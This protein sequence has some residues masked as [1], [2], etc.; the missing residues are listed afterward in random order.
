M[1]MLQLRRFASAVFVYAVLAQLAAAQAQTAAPKAKP[2]LDD[3]IRTL[4]SG[5]TFS[6]VAISPDGK[7]LAWV[8]SAKAGTSAIYVAETGGGPQP[9]RV[10]AGAGA[11]AAAPT[12]DSIAWSPDSKR[13]AFLSDAAK[14]GQA[15][16]YVVGA[17]GGPATK[18]TSVKGFLGSPGW[19]PDGKTIALLFTENAERAAGPLVAEKPQTGEIKEAVTEQRLTVVDVTSSRLRQ[20]SPADM[21]VYEY[22]WSPDGKRFVATA[23]H[24]NGDNNWYLAELYTLHAAGG[25]M[26]SI[27]KPPLQIANPAWSPDGT[28]IA[29]IAGL[30]SDEPAV[31]GDI[32]TI[33]EAGGQP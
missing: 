11:S 13:I 16:L 3:A 27:Y 28:A 9:R 6:Q 32:C 18:L 19:S 30:M 7:H 20:I 26:K 14:A 29:F 4:F 31:G 23:A 25:E 8:E 12:E 22:D 10:T 33:N 15:Q 24:G 21:Y 5:T 2:A 17:A 1:S